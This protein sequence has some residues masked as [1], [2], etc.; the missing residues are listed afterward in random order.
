M[1]KK[2]ISTKIHETLSSGSWVVPCGRTDRQTWQTYWSLFA[3]LHI[4]LKMLLSKFTYIMLSGL[5]IT[6]KS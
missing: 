3:I 6:K 5:Q 1:F 2:I 4:C